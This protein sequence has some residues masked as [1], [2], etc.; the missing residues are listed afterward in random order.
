MVIYHHFACRELTQ[1]YDLG[2]KKLSLY[3]NEYSFH[4][5]RTDDTIKQIEPLIICV[6]CGTRSSFLRPFTTIRHLLLDT[7]L[8]PALHI[9]SSLQYQG[10]NTPSSLPAM[11]ET[12]DKVLE[13]VKPSFFLLLLPSF[14]MIS[15]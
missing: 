2:P 7:P 4:S 6:E 12:I 14:H 11:R 15:P 10:S 3:I 1:T 8:A 9:L 13:D 5:P